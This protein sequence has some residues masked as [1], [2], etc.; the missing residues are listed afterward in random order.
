VGAAYHVD[1]FCL[2]QQLQGIVN[3][4]GDV[5]CGEMADDAAAR[6][7]YHEVLWQVQ[8]DDGDMREHIPAIV[9]HKFQGFRI[10]GDYH[11]GFAMAP[12]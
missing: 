5:I 3:R 2:G 11:V 9:H 6:F 12:L 10:H 4:A 7:R 8:G 1:K